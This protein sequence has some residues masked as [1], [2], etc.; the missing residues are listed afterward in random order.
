MAGGGG[1]GEIL[2]VLNTDLPCE[3]SIVLKP[4]DVDLPNDL[5]ISHICRD[6]KYTAILRGKRVLTVKNTLDDILRSLKTIEPLWR[7]ADR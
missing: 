6:G 5:R 2:V 4:D 1:I 3:I 7:Q